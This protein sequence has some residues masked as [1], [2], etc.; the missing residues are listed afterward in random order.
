MNLQ[1][2]EIFKSKEKNDTG[3]VLKVWK[4]IKDVLL[5]IKQTLE[6]SS[7]YTTKLDLETKEILTKAYMLDAIFNPLKDKNDAVW[8][9]EWF[10]F[11]GVDESFLYNV[12]A[13]NE[14]IENE[15]YY[16]TPSIWVFFQWTPLFLN[17]NYV[18]ALWAQNEESLKKDI[19]DWVALD[20]Y[21]DEWYAE[22]AKIAV[23]KLL[24]WKWYKNLILKTKERKTTDGRNIDSK[25]LCW[26]SFWNI[27]WLEIRIWNDVT[28]WTFN[29]TEKN[30]EWFEWLHLETLK[31]ILWYEEKIS[32]L[33]KLD[34]DSRNKLIIF[35]YLS[36][37]L[38]KIWNHWQF[39]MNVTIEDWEEYKMDFNTNYSS[40]LK[41]DQTE[42]EEKIKDW[43]LWEETYDTDSM[44]LIKWLMVCLIEDWYYV[45]EF[46]LKDKYGKSKIYSW[47]RFLI[48]DKDFNINRTFWI[49][50]NAIS[51]DNAELKKFLKWF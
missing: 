3:S 47:L 27:K 21:Y 24:E 7:K 33:M 9:L 43:T 32:G 4:I 44:S 1:G 26:N 30:L 18:Q 6:N 50:T 25:I 40:A 13:L 19:I 31:L 51:K 34:N 39:L 2:L 41:R 28:E 20:K 46:P 15:L 17:H 49:G 23:W 16:H 36:I 42:I 10:D 48:Q 12:N 14:W 37:I 45:A 35:S 8:D 5:K 22:K 11:S 29:K 38:D